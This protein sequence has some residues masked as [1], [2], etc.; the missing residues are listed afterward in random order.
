MRQEKH[1]QNQRVLQLHWRL[2]LLRIDCE[3]EFCDKWEEYVFKTVCKF[4]E[5]LK[6]KGR[7]RP[8]ILKEKYLKKHLPFSDRFLGSSFQLRSVPFDKRKLI[9]FPIPSQSK[10]SINFTRA[11]IAK[12]TTE[13]RFFGIQRFLNCRLLRFRRFFPSLPG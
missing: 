8:I 6:F 3:S 12:K 1:H 10:D 13:L 11:N 9:N 4:C 7:I 2:E 5:L